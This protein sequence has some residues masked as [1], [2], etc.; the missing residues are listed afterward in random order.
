MSVAIRLK[1]VVVTFLL[2]LL[3]TVSQDE[4]I[5]C[6]PIT[7]GRNFGYRGFGPATL[8]SMA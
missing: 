4:V 5:T 7:N 1:G 3:Q 8:L 6:K 2:L